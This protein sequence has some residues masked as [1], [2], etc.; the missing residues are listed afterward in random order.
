LHLKLESADHKNNHIEYGNL[1]GPYLYKG[2]KYSYE[3]EIRAFYKN[4]G[5]GDNISDPKFNLNRGELI[6]VDL[7]N[8]IEN[9]YIKYG[10]PVD[11]ST[12]VKEEIRKHGFYFNV[13]SSKL[14]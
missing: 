2:L 9:I 6:E 7:N 10:S 3:N 5:G 8:L 12:K 14:S 4:F 1:Y 13:S 11:F